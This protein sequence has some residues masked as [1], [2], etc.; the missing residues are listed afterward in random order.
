MRVINMSA[1]ALWATASMVGCNAQKPVEQEQTDQAAKLGRMD[2]AVVGRGSR[3]N[4]YQ[5]RQGV[6]VVQ[7]PASTEFF[8]TEDDPTRTTLS[9]D[10]A[11]G[12]YSVFLQEG[13]RLER[14][15]G[16]G[17][18]DDANTNG[19]DLDSGVSDG[20]GSTGGSTGS[21]TG[22]STGSG[23]HVKRV[24]ARLISGNPQRFY[25]YENER[26][27]V[28][29]QFQVGDEV[30]GMQGGYDIALEV[31]ETPTTLTPAYCSVD[32][33][34]ATGETCCLAGFLGQCR[35]LAEG[36]TCPLPD[37]TVSQETAAA[38][39]RIHHE[40]FA[41]DSCAIAEG[42]VAG[43]GDRRLLAFS[44]ETP[45]VGE[46]DMILGDPTGVPGF[47]YSSC[48][49][50]HH[51]E[52][53][54]TY[55]LLDQGGNVVATGHKQAFCLLDSEQV[56]DDA[57]SSPRYH[58][59]F[60]GIQAGW[61]D[62][63]TS[64]LDCQWVD[65]TGLPEGDYVLSISINTDRT[66]PEANYDNNTATIPVHISED[67]PP[68]AGDVLLDCAFDEAAEG[69]N[70]GFSIPQG[71]QGV[72]CTPG[73][74]VTV[75]CGCPNLGSCAGDP[76]MRICAGDEPC[77]SAQALSN[78]DDSCGACPQT[79]FVCPESGA[80]TVLAGAYDPGQAYACVPAAR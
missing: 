50:H 51:F 75:G 45:N 78:A 74:S 49:D 9:S 66:L 72:A 54:A 63:Y 43:A 36:D 67:R 19:G 68:V 3:G 27:Q 58:C 1:L 25:V 33:D 39:I 73:A 26:S 53:Y 11:T 77:L 52:G 31:D 61:S 32:A 7:G 20:G 71:M 14:I 69:R 4:I 22:G 6:V 34:C 59:G 40:T 41:A 37:L 65:I 56:L 18:E 30:V 23:A 64:D 2:V 42:C 24:E 62:V 55:R 16:D 44:T 76:V 57:S 46:A 60:Q 13:W 5:L 21:S 28:A 29:L 79:T 48:H 17:G 10:V 35:T 70:C 15:T 12:E 47:E 80:Y 8:N 38:T